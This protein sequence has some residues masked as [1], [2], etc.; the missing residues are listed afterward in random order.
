MTISFLEKEA[1]GDAKYLPMSFINAIEDFV[2]EECA[3]KNM[4]LGE[5]ADEMER[6]LT[7]IIHNYNRRANRIIKQADNENNA[8]TWDFEETYYQQKEGC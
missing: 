4:T 2:F 7:G 8:V 1:I 5:A 6:V 3:N